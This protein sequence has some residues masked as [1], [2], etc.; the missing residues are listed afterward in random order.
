[1][2]RHFS[3]TFIQQDDAEKTILRSEFNSLQSSK[4]HNINDIS[5]FYLY[6]ECL[7]SVAL[8]YLPLNFPSIFHIFFSLLYGHILISFLCL[9]ILDRKKLYMESHNK[10]E[11][12]VELIIRDYHYCLLHP[13]T[14]CYSLSLYIERYQISRAKLC[15]NSW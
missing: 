2:C 4:Y 13:L 15:L 12:A 3:T 14:P 1:M 9:G 5:N 10:S 11:E 6:K 8:K 7:H